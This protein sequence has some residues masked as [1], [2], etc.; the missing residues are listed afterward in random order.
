MVKHKQIS[1]GVGDVDKFINK[2]E[3][4]LEKIQIVTETSRC[5]MFYIVFFN[6]EDDKHPELDE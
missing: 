5:K 4:P 2:H 3:L 6:A 1:T